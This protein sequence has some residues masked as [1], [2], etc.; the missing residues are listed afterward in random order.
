MSRKFKNQPVEVD[1][2]RFPSKREARYYQELRYRER[3]GEVHNIELQPVF[4]IVID[5][6]PVRYRSGRALKYT[7]DFRF[8]DRLQRRTRVVDS[9]GH[10]TEAYKLRR[11]LVEHI[12]GIEVEEV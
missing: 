2:H 7:A 10:P 1:G 5:G 3:A 6:E 9:K 12:Y 8:Y 11:A 4:P